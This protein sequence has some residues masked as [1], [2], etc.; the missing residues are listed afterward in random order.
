MRGCARCSGACRKRARRPGRCP[1][2]RA[3]RR[4]RKVGGHGRAADRDRGALRLQRFAVFFPGVQARHGAAPDRFRRLAGPDGGGIAR[5]GRRPVIRQSPAFSR[6][7]RAIDAGRFHVH[8]ER[9]TTAR[10]LGGAPREA[11]FVVFVFSRFRFCVV[12]V[13]ANAFVNTAR[14]DCRRRARDRPGAGHPAFAGRTSASSRRSVARRRGTR[15]AARPSAGR[16]DCPRPRRRAR[17]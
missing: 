7:R 2:R 1:G 4:R 6:R 15:S 14:S 10:R 11:P 12:A 8:V 9:A 5:R 13:W 17:R 3:G 16:S